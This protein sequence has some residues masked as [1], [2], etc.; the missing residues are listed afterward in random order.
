M[1]HTARLQRC[2]TSG[3]FRF[4]NTASPIN[5]RLYAALFL[6]VGVETVDKLLNEQ[7]LLVR[8]LVRQMRV[9]L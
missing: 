4:A 9:F 2:C 6:A 3:C 8:A 1:P 5:G 7:D